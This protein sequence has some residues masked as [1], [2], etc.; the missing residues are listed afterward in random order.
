MV[1]RQ[2]GDLIG[3]AIAMANLGGAYE[4]LGD[5]SQAMEHFQQA[6]PIFR[7]A[8]H[9][10]GEAGALSGLGNVYGSLGEYSQAIEYFQ[11]AL[12]IVQ[13]EGDREFERIVLA[14]LGQVFADQ[15]ESEAAI[16][17]LQQ[18]VNVAESIR[19]GFDGL[20]PALQQ[21]YTDKIAESYRLL[22]TLLRQQGRLEEAQ[23]VLDLLF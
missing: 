5:Y 7:Q 16:E 10:N 19:Q 1:Y 20:S 2:I 13:Q 22:E 11:Q 17:A 4:S 14:D 21:S 12:P 9:R 15:N 18:S 23:Q 6:L 3:E 8:G